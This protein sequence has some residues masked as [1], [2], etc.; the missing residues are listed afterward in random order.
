MRHYRKKF[1]APKL[2]DTSLSGLSFEVTIESSPLTAE[3]TIDFLTFDDFRVN[4]I[5]VK[6]EE[7]D[8]PV[9]FQKGEPFVLPR[10]IEIFVSSGSVLEAAWNEFKNTQDKWLVTGRV[11][12]F[13]RFHKMG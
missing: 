12:A 3:G 7:F 13:G 8:G 9:S 5:P 10:P 1:A 6:I 2:V 11:F 4:S